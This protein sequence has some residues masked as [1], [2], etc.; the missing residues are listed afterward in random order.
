[1]NRYQELLKRINRKATWE[2]DSEFF[3]DVIAKS[4]I[5]LLEYC[6]EDLQRGNII[7]ILPLLRQVQENCVVLLGLGTE[8]LTVKEFVEGKID[9][10]RIIR[11]ITAKSNEDPK[12]IECMSEY[13]RGIKEILNHYAHTNLDGLMLLFMEDHQ[14]YETMKFNKVVV[15]FVIQMVEILFIPMVNHIYKTKI[16]VP[17]FAAIRRELKEIG[18]LKYTADKLPDG[19]KE[20]FQRSESLKDYFSKLISSFKQQ[21]AEVKEM[22]SV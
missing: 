16:D 13:M 18:S 1:M 8:S 22:K 9:P 14:T 4:T 20:F 10:K 7:R 21:L 6:Y 11:R 17:S 2:S 19:Y 12:K 15:R 5:R 3:K